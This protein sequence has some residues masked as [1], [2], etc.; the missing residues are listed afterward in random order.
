MIP[1]INKPFKIEDICVSNALGDS[2]NKFYIMSILESIA[3]DAENEM[4]YYLNTPD[5]TMWKKHFNIATNV[6]DLLLSLQ[7]VIKLEDFKFEV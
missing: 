2:L 1:L 3:L 6:E 5:T 7:K 4:M